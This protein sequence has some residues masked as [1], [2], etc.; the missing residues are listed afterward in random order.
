VPWPSDAPS[1]SQP[2]RGLAAAVVVALCLAL[3]SGCARRLRLDPLPA[4]RG[5]RVD[6]R[7]ELT[8]NRNDKLEIKME[9]PDPST[10]GPDYTR[11]VAWVA[12]PD[13]AHVSN[14]GQ[15]RINQRGRGE[16]N[17]KTALRSFWLYLTVEQRGD[18]QTPGPIVVFQ[19]PRIIEW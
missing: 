11:Y 18:T 14:V 5:G 12:T 3:L 4:A 19:S 15:I 10:Y 9:A 13:R 6:V 1:P 8:Y 17:A 2:R 7:V 16:L